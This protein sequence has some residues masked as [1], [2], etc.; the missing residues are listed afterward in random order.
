ML[1]AM[2]VV[3]M[4][5]LASTSGADML[6]EC[7]GHTSATPKRR[8]WTEL[9]AALLQRVGARCRDLVDTAVD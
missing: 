8:K 4:V 2:M 1:V 3:L 6:V 7:C 9:Q 5:V